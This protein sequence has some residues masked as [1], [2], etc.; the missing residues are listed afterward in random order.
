MARPK[1]D[2]G[3]LAVALAAA[4]SG[5][6]LAAAAA[7]GGVSESTLKRELRALKT[8]GRGIPQPSPPATSS[9][10]PVPPAATSSPAAA[11]T[12][13]GKGRGKVVAAVP[14]TTPASPPSSPT[15]ASLLG[16]VDAA[17]LDLG[18]DPEARVIGATLRAL[19]AGIPALDAGKLPQVANAVKTLVTTMRAM[20]PARALPPDAMDERLRELDRDAIAKID[21]YTAAADKALDARLAA[22]KVWAGARLPADLAAE[23]LAQLDGLFLPPAPSTVS[24]GTA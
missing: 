20:R 22:L 23:L 24:T 19:V 3:K 9:P 12:K 15:G 11:T 18:D 14:P 7:R 2:P 4:S 16:E 5:A 17:L 1:A 10:P 21:E 8:A 6:S 13:A